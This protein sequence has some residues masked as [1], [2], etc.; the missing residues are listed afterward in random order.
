MKELSIL[1]AINELQ[2]TC[3]SLPIPISAAQ[4]TSSTQT[5]QSCRTQVLI[6][7]CTLYLYALLHTSA[8]IYMQK[9]LPSA[10]VDFLLIQ[11]GT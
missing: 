9:G 11:T 1:V 5:H 3:K 10:I 2:N 7:M 4:T 8:S 6:L